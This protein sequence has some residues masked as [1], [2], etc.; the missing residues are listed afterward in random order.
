MS[1]LQNL[2][3]RKIMNEEQTAVFLPFDT[4]T[5]GLTEESSLLTA[6]FAVCD[7]YFNVI[8][9]LDLLIKPNNG[10]YVVNAEA[11]EVNHIDLKQHDKLAITY[12]EAGA[13]LRDFLWKHSK[14]GKIKLQP[15]G[16]NVNFDINKVNSTILGSK[17]WNQFVSY[18]QY[19]ITTVV[20][21]L[22]RKGILP[23][24]APESLQGIAEFLGIKANWHTAKG[25]NMAGIEVIRRL[26]A[27]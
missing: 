16:K 17:T 22:K 14:N 27:L 2:I 19:E 12:S 1:E 5:G 7:K 25:D 6:H 4:E 11:L 10:D 13:K 21:L 3:E 23:L 20:T 26:E 9:E 24:N 18:R 8:D 15:V